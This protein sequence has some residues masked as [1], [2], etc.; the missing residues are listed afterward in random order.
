MKINMN[1]IVNPAQ[2]RVLLQ[3][4]SRGEPQARF[5]LVGL[6]RVD[7][8][9]AGKS[10]GEALYMTEHLCGICPAA[11]HLAGTRCLDQL[12][13]IDG[14]GI[15]T[16]AESVRRLLHC[17]SHIEAHSL[18]FASLDRE[19]AV[20]L[21]KYSRRVMDA[22][23][24]GGHFPQTA[25][26]GGISQLPETEALRSLSEDLSPVLDAAEKLC[27]W[28]FR[29]DVEFGDTF[30]GASVAL[31]DSSGKPDLLGEYVKAVRGTEVLFLEP[32]ARFS[33]LITE[34]R[35]G[36]N[37]PRPYIVA[38]GIP[39]GYYRVG[40]IAQLSIGPLST[41]RA[42][43]AQN[44]WLGGAESGGGLAAR[45]IIT[46]H[47]LEMV[48]QLAERILELLCVE[49]ERAGTT[50]DEPKP[51]H[52][53]TATGLVDSPRGILQHTYSIGEDGL[54]SSATILTPTVQNEPWLAYLLTDA[55]RL[56]GNAREAAMEDALRTADPCLPISAAPPGTMNLV[57]EAGNG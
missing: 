48:E 39:E 3:R 56:E 55:V 19:A 18:R 51:L 38:L 1:E 35:P 54:V 26:P 32:N 34:S 2:G 25:L 42:R 7:T 23:G 4:D 30:V 17:G 8:L 46:L 24:A 28:A 47:C 53:G 43:A 57:I 50:F 27:E 6:P 33:E 12:A 45:A 37:V 49:E 44:R 13:V 20:T 10:A 11:H 9:L 29:S 36:E 31:A 5:D 21:K 40:P 16:L 15:S 52:A 22:A 41:P 14:E